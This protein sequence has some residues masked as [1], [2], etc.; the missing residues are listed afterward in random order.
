MTYEN[1]IRNDKKMMSVF[2]Y[3]TNLYYNTSTIKYYMELEDY[4]Q[5]QELDLYKRFISYY[6]EKKYNLS[7]FIIKSIKSTNINIYNITVVEKN[8]SNNKNVNL[9][10]DSPS[11]DELNLTEV[12]IGDDDVECDIKFLINNL[13]VELSEKD[14]KMLYLTA[15]N[16][17]SREID[18]ILGLKEQTTK[19][20]LRRIRKKFNQTLEL[21]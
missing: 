15:L 1:K 7:T 16:Y 19:N 12:L 5:E 4:K 21:V 2:N 3:Y 9:S 10:L 18:R 20:N 6:D 17:S 8:F 11:D 14:K 13:G